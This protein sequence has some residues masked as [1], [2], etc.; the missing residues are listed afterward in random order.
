MKVFRELD[1]NSQRNLLALFAAGVMYWSS[2]S[3]HQPVLPIY[4]AKQ[5]LPL[6]IAPLGETSQVGFVMGCFAIGLFVFRPQLGKLVDCKS[7]KLVLG[8][9]MVAVAIA[10]L[11]YWLF[12]TLGC[13]VLFRIIHGF[14]LAAFDTAFI[15]LVVDS[16]P[17]RHRGEIVGAM[18]LGGT[19]GIMFGPAFGSFL[20]GTLGDAPFFWLASG[21]GWLGLLCLFPI[22]ES[23]PAPSDAAK[24]G[25]DDCFWGRL[26]EPAFWVPAFILLL[27]GLTFGSLSTY[28]PL[29]SASVVENWNPGWFYTASAISNLSTRALVGRISDRVGRGLCIAVSLFLYSMSL[30]SLS[31]AHNEQTFFLAGLLEGNGYGTLIPMVATLIADR[32]RPQERARLFSLCMMG[33]DLGMGIGGPLLG[34]VATAI[35]YRWM[36]ALDGGLVILSLVVF[37]T[38]ANQGIGRSLRFSVGKEPDLH[39][40]KEEKPG[41]APQS[42]PLG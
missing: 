5:N 9:G 32:S 21:L 36:F 14:S 7:Q 24:S 17:P 22:Q 30:F 11:G 38:Q 35:G 20:Q 4:I 25:T 19:L 12:P 39:A 2:F 3:A 37:M 15:V 13:M 18:T 29:F 10:P 31:L 33:L 26:G 6:A 41:V 27:A 28:M 40:V 42:I 16:V 34:L 1:A 8:F 23:A